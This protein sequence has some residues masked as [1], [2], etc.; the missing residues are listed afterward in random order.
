M[1]LGAANG[2]YQVAVSE[3]MCYISLRETHCSTE[4]AT[5]A[6][7]SRHAQAHA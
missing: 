1:P 6:A 4:T 3:Y 5:D 2:S 7:T